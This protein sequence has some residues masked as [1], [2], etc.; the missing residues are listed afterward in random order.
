MVAFQASLRDQ[1][2]TKGE[3]LRAKHRPASGRPPQ[4]IGFTV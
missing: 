1:A 2:L 4:G 3:R